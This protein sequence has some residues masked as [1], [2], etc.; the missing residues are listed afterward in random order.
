MPFNY[1]EFQ[2]VTEEENGTPEGC[3][4]QDA[5]CAILADGV[6]G[7]GCIDIRKPSR[8]EIDEYAFVIPVRSIM[9]SVEVFEDGSMNIFVRDPDGKQTIGVVRVR[10]F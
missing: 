10:A 5:N 8:Y 3:A 1:K 6:K 9:S 4:K 2:I 7:L